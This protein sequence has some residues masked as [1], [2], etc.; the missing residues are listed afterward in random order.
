MKKIIIRISSVLLLLSMLGAFVACNRKSTE[1]DNQTTSGNAGTSD[2]GYVKDSIPANTNF[3]GQKVVVLYDESRTSEFDPDSAGSFVE[4]AIV[5]R[6]FKVKSR[7]NVELEFVPTTGGYNNRGNAPFKQT[8]LA[9]FTAGLGSYD[10]CADYGMTIGSCSIEG[11]CAN[12]KDYDII[13]L[14]APWWAPDLNTSA[15]ING[16]LFFGTGDI[17]TSYLSSMYC[18]FFNEDLLLSNN[19]EIPYEMVYMDNWKWEFFMQLCKGVY[20]D[21]DDTEGASKG[22][23]FALS[24]TPVFAESIFYSAGNKFLDMDSEGNLILSESISNSRASDFYDMTQSFLAGSDCYVIGDG[25]A[26][27]N[28]QNQKSMFTV[29]SISYASTLASVDMKFGVLPMPKYDD[30]QDFHS[31]CWV[32]RSLYFICNGS[33]IPE[34]AATVFECMASEGYRQV[35][36]V[37]YEDTYKIRYSKDEDCGKMIDIIRNSIVFDLAQVYTYSFEN[38]LPTR[39]TRGLVAGTLY[40]SDAPMINLSSAMSTYGQAMKSAV[41]NISKAYQ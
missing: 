26:A 23:N 31:A 27:E 18:M 11:L 15:T 13:D 34:V 32:G 29:N 1:P 9:D 30:N 36:K 25:S 41:E 38:Q 40:M 5:N 28:F 19:I 2:D 22:D 37:L 10:I 3:D 8:V 17:S 33:S 21:A 12:L 20:S 24:M 39:L 14:S 35:T 16:K 6:N 7:L 4:Q